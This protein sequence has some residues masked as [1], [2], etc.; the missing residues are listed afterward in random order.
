MPNVRF[1]REGAPHGRV[2]AEMAVAPSSAA[3]AWSAA[4]GSP[5]DTALDDLTTRQPGRRLGLA[6]TD[7]ADS[8]VPPHQFRNSSVTKP[9]EVRESDKVFA[10]LYEQ[11]EAMR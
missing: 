2:F 3:S 6:S 8:A 11:P 10:L 7:D 4:R 5:V 9:R 1:S